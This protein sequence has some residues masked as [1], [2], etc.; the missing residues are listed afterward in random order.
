MLVLYTGTPGSGKSLD[1]AIN[2]YSW[3]RRGRHV[4][5]NFSINLDLVSKNCKNDITFVKFENSKI[6]PEVFVNYSREYRKKREAKGKRCKEGELKLIFDEAQVLFSSRRWQTLDPSWL[7]FFSQSR[8]YFYDIILICQIDEMIDKQIRCLVEYEYKHRKLS[9]FGIFGKILNLFYGGKTFCK[10]T[11]WYPI[12]ERLG[13]EMF[14][15]NR[16]YADLYDTYEDFELG[17]H[18]LTVKEAKKLEQ[19]KNKEAKEEKNKPE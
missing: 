17:D 19:K 2:M 5:A 7:T 6:T 1:C 9:N 14:H 16:K 10:I 8:K 18:I 11:Y 12:K 13:S 3:L 4:L 15:F